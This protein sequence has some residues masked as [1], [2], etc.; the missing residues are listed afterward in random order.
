MLSSLAGTR[1]YSE[2]LRGPRA[3]VDI[4]VARLAV[5]RLPELGAAVLHSRGTHG[6]LVVYSLGTQGYSRGTHGYLQVLIGYSWVLK[7]YS[8]GAHVDLVK[9]VLQVAL[10]RVLEENVRK[11]A[12]LQLRHALITATG[13][14]NATSATSATNAKMQQM[15]QCN[16]ETNATVRY[17]PATTRR[18]SCNMRRN[19]GAPSG[20]L[21]RYSRG[22]H[23]YSRGTHGALMGT[24]GVL[25]GYSRGTH[26]VLTGTHGYSRVLTGGGRALL[27]PRRTD[28]RDGRRGG[29]RQGGGTEAV[30]VGA[31]SRGTHAVP[32]RY[33]RGTRTRGSAAPL[34]SLA[35]R[36]L[37]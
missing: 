21:T 13:A 10:E 17:A 27:Q 32:T 37:F 1:G 6:V 7:G 5:E 4:A 33:P 31:G 29:R 24:H 25:T 8:R 22:T 34:T 26:G 23:G 15:H 18:A 9:D 28:G 3:D 19:A 16:N 36:V 14:A 30:P 20:R 35:P 2:C 11:R 12:V